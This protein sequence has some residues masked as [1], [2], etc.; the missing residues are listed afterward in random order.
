MPLDRLS[1]QKFGQSHIEPFD[2][3]IA[4]HAQRDK[5]FDKAMNI[6]VLLEQAPIEPADHVILAIGVVVAGLCSPHLVAHNEHRDTEGQEGDSQEVLHLLIS[7][8]LNR[9]FVSRTLA[10][11]IPAAVVVRTIAIA[12]T[13]RLVVFSVVRYEIVEREA[14]MTG[15]EIDGLFGLTFL[16]PIDLRASHQPVC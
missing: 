14:V 13:I 15:N 11:A 16:V 7:E 10:T 6:R 8:P 4:V 5:L 3:Q 9:R 12:L 1:P 2:R